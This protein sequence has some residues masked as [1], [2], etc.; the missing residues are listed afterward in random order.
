VV[1]GPAPHP[2]PRAAARAA[3][4][5][6]ARRDPGAPLVDATAVGTALPGVDKRQPG[7]SAKNERLEV[8]FVAPS[9]T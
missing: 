1:P 8:V 9:A 7:A 5:V 3:R 4:A 6:S 2:A